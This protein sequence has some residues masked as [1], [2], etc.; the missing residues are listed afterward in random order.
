[1]I[2]GTIT[3][4][5]LI[6][7]VLYE[8]WVNEKNKADILSLYS[9]LKIPEIKVIYDRCDYYLD[10]LLVDGGIISK[11]EAIQANQSSAVINP[12]SEGGALVSAK[13]RDVSE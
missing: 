3:S 12:P 7:I 5:L 8:I 6:L 10:N 1:M 11:H 2:I 9:L 13:N 4:V